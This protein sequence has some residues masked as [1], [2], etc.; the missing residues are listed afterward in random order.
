MGA[1]DAELAMSDF[2]A[3]KKW[4]ATTHTHSPKLKSRVFI[5]NTGM[6]LVQHAYTGPGFLPRAL[7]RYAPLL[8]MHEPS[9]IRKEEGRLLGHSKMVIKG[10]RRL[11]YQTM[12]PVAAMG[13]GCLTPMLMV[14]ILSSTSQRKWGMK[15]ILGFEGS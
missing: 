15:P 5:C 3:L 1:L 14:I 2:K 11:G 8:C 10:T 9:A 13:V 6:F 7:W 12:K 4:I